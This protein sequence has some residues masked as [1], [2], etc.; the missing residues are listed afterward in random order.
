MPSEILAVTFTNKAA[1][2]MRLRFG[3]LLGQNSANRGFMPWIGTFHV[4]CVRL[5]RIEG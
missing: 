1:R 3:T 5:L 4:I 2:E